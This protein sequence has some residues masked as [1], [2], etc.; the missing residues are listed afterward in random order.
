MKTLSQAM[1]ATADVQASGQY[2]LGRH[3]AIDATAHDL[4]DSI[5][6]FKHL[7]LSRC[8][9]KMAQPRRLVGEHGSWLMERFCP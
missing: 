3:A 5:D 7:L 1:G 2:T 8:S 9:G 6:T 4:P